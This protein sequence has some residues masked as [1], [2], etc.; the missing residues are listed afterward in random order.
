MGEF[1]KAFK[2]GPHAAL[3]LGYH[4]SCSLSKELTFSYALK[5]MF[6]FGFQCDLNQSAD[7][8]TQN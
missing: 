1:E 2:I 3:T 7:I 5:N 4:F 8:F 6:L